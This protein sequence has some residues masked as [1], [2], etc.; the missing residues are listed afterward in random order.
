M[1]EAAVYINPFDMEILNSKEHNP[2]IDTVKQ[3]LLNFVVEQLANETYDHVY[4]QLSRHGQ[5]MSPHQ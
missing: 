2:M 4:T 1:E 3:R 5:D